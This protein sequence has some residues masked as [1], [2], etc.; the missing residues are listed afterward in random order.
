M[1]HESVQSRFNIPTGDSAEE[2]AAL[3]AAEPIAEGVRVTFVEGKGRGVVALRDFAP[4]EILFEEPPYAAV[5]IY[6]CLEHI[7]SGEFTVLADSEK[8]RSTCSGCKS[9]RCANCS[10]EIILVCSKLC[11]GSGDVYVLLAACIPAQDVTNCTRQDFSIR[12]R[13]PCPSSC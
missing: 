10:P 11:R 5:V 7:C 4:G 3:C 9:V 12:C 6:A 8:T 2:Q 1:V 13:G